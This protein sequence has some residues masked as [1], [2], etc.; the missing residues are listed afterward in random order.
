M[1]IFLTGVLAL[2]TAEGVREINYRYLLFE[3]RLIR[4]DSKEPRG[5]TRR[6]LPRRAVRCNFARRSAEKG[7]ESHLHINLYN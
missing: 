4:F 3:R 6:A 7:E 1:E 2:I 5:E